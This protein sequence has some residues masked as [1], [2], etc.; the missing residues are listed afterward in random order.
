MIEDVFFLEL[1]NG[2]VVHLEVVNAEGPGL[3]AL[4]PVIRSGVRIMVSLRGSTGPKFSTTFSTRVADKDL[5]LTLFFNTAVPTSRAATSVFVTLGADMGA[6]QKHLKDFAV[7]KIRGAWTSS[8]WDALT[9]ITGDTEWRKMWE[10]CVSRHWTAAVAATAARLE[11]LP[12]PQKTASVGDLGV[13][14]FTRHS[15][16]LPWDE[17]NMAGLETRSGEAITKDNLLAELLGLATRCRGG[18]AGTCRLHQRLWY[19]LG[20]MSSQVLFRALTIVLM[21][22]KGAPRIVELCARA[23]LAG[24]SARAA[25]L[26]TTNDELTSETAGMFTT[27]TPE[28]SCPGQTWGGFPGNAVA[29]AIRG[30]ILLE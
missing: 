11:D 8:E 3:S 18:T 16:S 2:E 26:W 27:D 22:T 25:T 12:P 21:M 13:S 14:L 29:E 7:S 20:S 5:T 6:H 19:V 1:S 9:K 4:P 24:C 30:S 10:G 15:R 28:I 23:A 17:S